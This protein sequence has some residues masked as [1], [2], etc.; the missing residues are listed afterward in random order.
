MTSLRDRLRADTAP[1]HER[2][3]RAY[4]TLDLRQAADLGTFLGA[5]LAVLLA[6]RCRPGPHAKAADDL[7]NGMAAAIRS[8]LHH[9]DRAPAL[10]Q[11]ACQFDAT[12]VLYILLGSCLGK[13]VLQRR[14]LEGSDPLTA[15]AGRYLGFAPP[16]DAWRTFCGELMKRPPQGTEADR[17][18]DD[19]CLLFELHL[20]ALSTLA[21]A[22]HGGSHAA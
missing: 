11:Q 7:R 2:V 16:S 4:T 17:V 12:S 18:V 14:W 13:R 22:H 1:W 21:P 3:D 9:L 20:G 10:P 15:G 8:D 5:Q 19:A 6:I